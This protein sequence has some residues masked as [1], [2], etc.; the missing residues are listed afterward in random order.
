MKDL[1]S[2]W[3]SSGLTCREVTDRVTDYLEGCLSNFTKMRI[4]LHLASCAG[5][6]SYVKQIS[7]LQDTLALLPKMTPSPINRLRL[8]RHFAAFHPN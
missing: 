5:C 3:T 2:Q 4:G 8:R 6:R 1:P 7:L